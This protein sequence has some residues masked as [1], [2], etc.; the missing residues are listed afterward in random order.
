MLKIGDFSKLGR[1][2]VKALRLYD[3]LGLLKPV[4]VD[5]WNGYRYY[6]AGQLTRLNRIITLK[7]LGF[8]LEQVAQIMSE[9]VSTEQIRGMLRLKRAEIQQQVESDTAWLAQIE[10]RL[11]QLEKEDNMDKSA[12]VIKKLDPQLVAS[13]R[14][15]IPMYQDVVRLHVELD[16]YFKARGLREA[17]SCMSIFHDPVFKEHDADTEAA[18]PIAPGALESN[19]RVQVRELPGVEQAACLVYQGPYEGLGEAHDA[20]HPWIADNGYRICGPER[21]VYVHNREHTSDPAQFVTEIQAPV[22]KA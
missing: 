17:A 10:A 6:A 1:V 22:E 20:L 4:E 5:R 19:G 13:L 11:R 12:V 18:F 16:A 9:S 3:E 7:E 8:S 15:V 21:E 14:E 2:T